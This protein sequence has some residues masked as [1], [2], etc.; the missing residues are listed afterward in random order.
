MFKLYKWAMG[1]VNNASNSGGTCIYGK[2]ILSV[3]PCS[4]WVDC[5]G[6][7]YSSYMIIHGEIRDFGTFPSIVF[8]I[9][10]T[11]TQLISGCQG[12]MSIFY[13]QSYCCWLIPLPYCIQYCAKIVLWGEYC[14]KIV[15][16][17]EANST[18]LLLYSAFRKYLFTVQL[19]PFWYLLSTSYKISWNLEAGR[20]VEWIIATLYNLTTA[21]AAM[22]PRCLLNFRVIRQYIHV[23]NTNL[24]ALRLNEIVW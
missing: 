20:L 3:M 2:R 21:S 22:L 19:T 1:S 16:W 24:P 9:F 11:C 14:A 5:H 7:W 8:S 13:H 10:C 4:L 17:G 15:L 23:Q 6:F 18:Y 12:H